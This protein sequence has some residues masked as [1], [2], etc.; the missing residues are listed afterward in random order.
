MLKL[1]CRPVTD[2]GTA[3][4][5]QYD[6]NYVKLHFYMH[7]LFLLCFQIGWSN[8]LNNKL[9][10]WRNGFLWILDTH[11]SS[12]LLHTQNQ[13]V[14]CYGH[15]SLMNPVMPIMDQF[16]EHLCL[17]AWIKT[18]S[19]AYSHDCALYSAFSGFQ[20]RIFVLRTLCSLRFYYISAG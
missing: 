16:E 13:K 10:P 6:K 2:H 4:I 17:T 20:F 5:G 3:R 19:T 11:L 1:L 7:F 14:R 15:R 9:I 12:N 8:C 18:I